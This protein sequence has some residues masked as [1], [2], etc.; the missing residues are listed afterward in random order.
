MEV[1]I[2]IADKAGGILV[3]QGSNRPISIAAQNRKPDGWMRGTIRKVFGGRRTIV[4]VA[5]VLINGN[6]DDRWTARVTPRKEQCGCRVKNTN[7][8]AGIKQL[9]GRN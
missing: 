2:A 5:G 8:R 3:R 7:A 6:S 9:V 1:R 4:R